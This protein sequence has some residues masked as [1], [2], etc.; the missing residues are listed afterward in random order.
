ML[1]FLAVLGGA[2]IG[3][4]LVAAPAFAGQISAPTGNPYSWTG[5]TSGT[6]IYQDVSVSN[7]NPGQQVYLQVCDGTDP[8]GPQW[9]A[10]LNCDLVSTPAALIMNGSGAGTFQATDVNHRFRPFKGESPS[11]LFICLSPNDPVPANPD[12]LPVFRNCKI[13]ATSN[14]TT[15]TTDQT[16]LNIKLPD[17]P[18]A[19]VPEVPFALVLPL[20]AVAVGGAFFVI[21]KRQSARAVA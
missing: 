4:G 1:K 13:R 15:A 14:A 7:F 17:M 10:S 2:A 8:A 19:P 3:V 16:F 6:P 5:D 18:T 20:G 21:R 9:D 12:G 11:S